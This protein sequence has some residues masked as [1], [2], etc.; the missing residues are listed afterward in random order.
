MDRRRCRTAQWAAAM[1]LISGWGVMVVA[2]ASK[3][4]PVA[5]EL[6]ALMAQQKL[7]AFAAKDP[8]MPDAYVAAMLFP[9]VQLLV[10]GGR[11][12]AVALNRAGLR[13]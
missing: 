5:R 7:H 2:E 8:Q 3:S 1:L 13:R 10:V 12:T 6:A 9:N 11:P 4:E